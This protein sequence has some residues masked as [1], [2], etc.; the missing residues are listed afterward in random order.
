[1]Q[2]KSNTPYYTLLWAISILFFIPIVWVVLAA[3][4]TDS[5][6]LAVPAKLVFVP[7][8]SQI[9][10]T[11]FGTGE[12]VSNTLGYFRNSLIL[13]IGSV[14]LAIVVSFLAAFAFFFSKGKTADTII[15]D[16]IHKKNTLNVDQQEEV[17]KFLWRIASSSEM[18]ISAERQSAFF[19]KFTHGVILNL[20]IFISS[21]E[22][23]ASL[24]NFCLEKM[25]NVTRFIL[26]LMSDSVF[27]LSET[28]DFTKMTQLNYTIFKLTAE[29][30]AQ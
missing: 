13:S 18:P 27:I 29:V 24:L 11:I 20:D 15:D 12:G 3:F 22:N 19:E 17:E 5:D 30:N 14:L 26:E 7:T 25:S 28:I 9:S 2:T 16:Y 6:I 23:S 1:M 21:R 4:K 8:L 10:K